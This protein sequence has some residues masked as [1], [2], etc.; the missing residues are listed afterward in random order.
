[1]SIQ[2]LNRQNLS[3]YTTEV[4]RAGR[5]ARPEVKSVSLDGSDLV[6]KDYRSGKSLFGR[7]LGRFLVLREKAAYECLD[8]LR[9]VPHYYGTLDAYALI[10]QHMPAQRVTEVAPDAVPPGFFELLAEI[11]DNLHRRGIAHGDLHKL[12]N[13]LIDENA[14]PVILDFTSAIMTGSNPLAVLLFS[15]LCEDDWRGV[16]KLKREIAPEQLTA[17]ERE[18]LA[19]RSLGERLFRRVREPFRTLIKRWATD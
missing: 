1:M 10:L 3:D 18:F 5:D 19:R 7:L 14:E 2:G 13:I 17:Q 9:G 4:V 12:D 6:V 8:G 16:Y 11:V 15:A